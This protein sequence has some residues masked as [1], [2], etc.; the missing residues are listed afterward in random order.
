[1]SEVLSG[2]AVIPGMQFVMQCTQGMAYQRMV[3]QAD[4]GLCLGPDQ[5]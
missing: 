1:M 3:A 5:V 4:L 2:L